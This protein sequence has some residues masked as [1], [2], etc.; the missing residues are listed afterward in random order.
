MLSSFW[1]SRGIRLE[2]DGVRILF[3]VKMTYVTAMRNKYSNVNT[4][5]GRI[6]T[7]TVKLL[8]KKKKNFKDIK[9]FLQISQNFC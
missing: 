2:M 7:I 6:V 4:K 8:G 9:S 5:S 1:D 3:L